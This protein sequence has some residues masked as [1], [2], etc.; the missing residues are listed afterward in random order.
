MIFNFHPWQLDVNVE[1]TK[2][3]YAEN[4]DSIDKV[5]NTEFID[6]LS[7]EQQQFFDS[8]GVDLMK[9]EIDKTIY[10]IPDDEEISVQK[11]Y[12]VSANFLIKGKILGLPQYQKD[13]YGDEDVFGKEFPTS[14]KVLS[15]EDE[16]YLKPYDNGIGNGIVFKHPGLHYDDK[17]F[18]SWDCGYIL[19]GYTQEQLA[20]YLGVTAPA[21]SKWETAASYP[22]ITLLPALARLLDTDLNT[23]LSFKEDLSQKEINVFM[24]QLATIADREG[25]NSTYQTAMEKIREFPSCYALILNV[26][27][28]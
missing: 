25:I 20:D 17:K 10:E 9:V 4:D 5:A 1:S 8:L 11:L 6:K 14:I 2:Q 12:K 26:A 28:F 27:L 22:D 15:S 18:E 3:F 16:D 24:N 7:L 21:I 19:G 13:L 23:L